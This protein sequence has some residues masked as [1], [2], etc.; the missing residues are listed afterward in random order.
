[1]FSGGSASALAAKLAEHLDNRQ[2]ASELG[3][4]GQ[5]AVHDRYTADRMASATLEMYEKTLQYGHC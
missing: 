1:M 3:T 4:R 2:Q 5:A